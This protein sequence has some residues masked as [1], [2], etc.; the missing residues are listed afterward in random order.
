MAALTLYYRQ[1]CHLCEDFLAQLQDLIN[2]QSHTLTLVDVDSNA[3]LRRD[4]GSKV[5]VLIGT[6]GE[7]C[8]YE[9]DRQSLL[10]Y[11][12]SS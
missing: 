4:F 6:H 9:L 3:E 11:L 5:P 12:S 2:G 10:G 1:N 7:L 8:Y